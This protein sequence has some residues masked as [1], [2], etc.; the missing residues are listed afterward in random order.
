MLHRRA[1]HTG[2]VACIVM[3]GIALAVACWFAG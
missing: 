2:I 1:R 3:L